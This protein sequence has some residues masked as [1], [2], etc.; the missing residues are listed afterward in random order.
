MRE[1]PRDARLAMETLA[2]LR[3]LLE[4]GEH[5]LDGDPAS[6]LLVHRRVDRA[7]GAPAD[8]LEDPV[9]PDA[10]RQHRRDR[11]QRHGSAS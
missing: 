7:H 5:Q 6:E 8:A 10:L 3:V 1:L 11:R 4:G 2:Q 9:A